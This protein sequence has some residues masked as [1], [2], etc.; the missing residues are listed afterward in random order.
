MT[1]VKDLEILDHPSEP[2]VITNPQ[3]QMRKARK[4]GGGEAIQSVTGT[5]L[6]LLALTVEEGSHE[7][8]D[9]SDL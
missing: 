9:L 1:K 2:T 6:L 8:R 7:S 5:Q 4:L 3:M